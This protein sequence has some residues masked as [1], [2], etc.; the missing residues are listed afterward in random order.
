L[1]AQGRVIGAGLRTRILGGKAIDDPTQTLSIANNHVPSVF[2][3]D[4][5]LS[6]DFE[7]GGTTAQFF[8]AATNLLDKDPQATG[9]FPVSLISYP[10]QANTQLYDVLGQRFTFGVKISM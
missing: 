2:Y 3:L 5:R 6:Y 9:S 1:F 10:V 4:A 7:F 8:V